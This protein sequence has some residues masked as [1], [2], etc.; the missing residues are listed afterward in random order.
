MGWVEAM[1]QPLYSGP[2][3]HACPRRGCG[4]TVPNELYACSPC[5]G[6]LDQDAKNAIVRTRRLPV[7]HPDRRAAFA[8]ANRSWGQ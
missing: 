1:N 6:A 3:R 8:L 5:W 4:Q 7:L 2:G